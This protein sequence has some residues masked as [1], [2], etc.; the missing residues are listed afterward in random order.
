M[1]VQRQTFVS[2]LTS[3]LLAWQQTQIHMCSHNF[4]LQFN[5][6][7]QIQVLEIYSFLMNVTML[8]PLPFLKGTLGPMASVT[9]Q[10]L[11]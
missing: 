11:T 6:F 2:E 7:C 8:S 3:Y 9:H 5:L 4:V 1:N 10:F